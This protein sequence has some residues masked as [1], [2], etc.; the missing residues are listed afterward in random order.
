MDVRVTR[1]VAEMQMQMAEMQVRERSQR[2]QNGQRKP[3][4]KQIR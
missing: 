3:S 1:A 4:V 2:R